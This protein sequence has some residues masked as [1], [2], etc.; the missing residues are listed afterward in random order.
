MVIG[1]NASVDKNVT[2]TVVVY[3]EFN[4]PI[5]QLALHLVAPAHTS[6]VR[7]L[8][9]KIPSWAFLGDTTAYANAFTDLPSNGGI[10]YCPEI[11]APFNIVGDS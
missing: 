11:S 3:D 1:N 6:V 5:G 7:V 2:L 10:A 9:W 4:L 8:D